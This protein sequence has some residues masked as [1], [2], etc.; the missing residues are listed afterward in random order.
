[1]Q[2]TCFAISDV[3]MF[4][5]AA[6]AGFVAGAGLIV[7]I[8]AQNAFVLRQG[9]LRRHVGLVVAICTLGDIVLIACGV[10][11]IGTLAQAWPGLAQVLRFGGAAFLGAYGLMAAGRA[12]RGSGLLAP[13]V[14]TESGWRSVM[15]ACLA[16][17]F[18]NPHVYLDTMVLLGSLSTRYPD[19]AR[20][21]FAVG[22]W[23]ASLAWFSALGYGARLLL[24]VFRSAS[25]WRALDAVIAVFMLSLCF[26]LLS[27]P[28]AGE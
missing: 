10:A 2:D 6:F 7:A 8:G 27:H 15:L 17:T 12:W 20:W 18:L 19:P 23:G 25:A 1:V 28:L 26:L 5:V 14:G 9:L 16:F 3:I 21:A 22:A 4:L 24:P 11:G 13:I